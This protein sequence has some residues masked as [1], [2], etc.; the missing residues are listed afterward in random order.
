MLPSEVAATAINVRLVKGG[1]TVARGSARREG[2]VTL[3]HSKRIRPGR[4]TLA[5]SF[6]VGGSSVS[7]RQPVRVR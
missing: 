6:K 7:A 3:R 5:V 4:Y 1:N 2:R